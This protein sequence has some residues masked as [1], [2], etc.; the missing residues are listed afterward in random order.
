M[1]EIRIDLEMYASSC[2]KIKALRK[3]IKELEKVKR[4]REDKIKTFLKTQECESI[5]YNDYN[6]ELR[7]VNKT[8]RI[9]AHEESARALA[10][11]HTYGVRDA[12]EALRKLK[13][14]TKIQIEQLRLR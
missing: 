1:S 5:T 11:L 12:E 9:R 10:I 7:A 6:I 8:E 13:T 3:E 2:E 4:A 14:K